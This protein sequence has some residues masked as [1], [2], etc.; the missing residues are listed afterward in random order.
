MLMGLRSGYQFNCYGDFYHY[1]LKGLCQ[2]D[3]AQFLMTGLILSQ[4]SKITGEFS[5]VERTITS[6]E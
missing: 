3:F 1:D 2:Q 6:L 5:K 4:Q